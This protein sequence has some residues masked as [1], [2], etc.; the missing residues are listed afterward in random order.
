MK[1]GYA[2]PK[3]AEDKAGQKRALENYGCD[4]ILMERIGKG[5]IRNNALEKIIDQLRPG[6]ELVVSSIFQ[7][8]M[9]LLNLIGLFDGLYKN[10]V[11][12]MCIEEQLSNGPSYGV[13]NA[14]HS[15]SRSERSRASLPDPSENTARQRG[16]TDETKQKY[17]AIITLRSQNRSIRAIK[18]ELEM[19]STRMIYQAF[20]L[21]GDPLKEVSK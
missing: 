21:Y 7:F 5:K 11:K 3:D 15:R 13:L 4:S 12:V 19:K 16:I 20:E 18:S 6:D 14:Y 9:T 17:L 8:P 2:R 10:Q 1:Y